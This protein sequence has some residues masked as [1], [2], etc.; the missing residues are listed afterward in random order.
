MQ[1]LSTYG[2][3]KVLHHRPTAEVGRNGEASLYNVLRLFKVT[4]HSV[5]LCGQ[6][7]NTKARS[8]RV[9]LHLL[10]NAKGL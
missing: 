5:L 1:V 9:M 4:V 6:M 8:A 10:L 2:C 3:T 7:H